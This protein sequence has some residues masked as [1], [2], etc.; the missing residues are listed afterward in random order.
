AAGKYPLHYA[1][2]PVL[3]EHYNSD[4]AVTLLA[5]NIECLQLADNDNLTPIQHAALIGQSILVG[6]LLYKLKNEAD[7]LA[8]MQV[9]VNE[10]RSVLQIAAQDGYHDFI[11]NVRKTG[12]MGKKKERFDI[13]KMDTV[14]YP[15][16]MTPVAIAYN[17]WQTEQN[18][19]KKQDFY[20]FL[21]K[22]LETT[23]SKHMLERYMLTRAE[24]KVLI[25]VM[26]LLHDK[27]CCN[28]LTPHEYL[29]SY[30]VEF[31]ICINKLQHDGLKNELVLLYKD[32]FSKFN[33]LSLSQ[34]INRIAIVIKS[35]ELCNVLLH[36]TAKGRQEVA[37]N[38]YVHT[39]VYCH[40]ED[41]RR[42]TMMVATVASTFVLTAAVVA[43][44]CTMT[45]SGPFLLAAVS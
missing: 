41:I 22:Y 14:K 6:D 37:G 30:F 28:Y 15:L 27:P 11:D 38:Y 40:D 18:P 2:R 7:R 33:S 23:F 20:D 1:C 31:M 32:L 29:Q 21:A 5:A 12:E 39:R 8:V 17:G 16:G 44:A 36:G 19:E 45:M 13:F 43:L 4:N 42:R 34:Q 35:I 3:Q 25:D 24:Q 26:S 9:G 10:S